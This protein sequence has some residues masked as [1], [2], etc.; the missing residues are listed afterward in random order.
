MEKRIYEVEVTAIIY[1]VTDTETTR[2]EA[3]KEALER[4]YD[5]RGLEVTADMVTAVTDLGPSILKMPQ[6]K[7]K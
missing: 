2:E 1:H 7:V 4:I 3:I 6:G 5:E